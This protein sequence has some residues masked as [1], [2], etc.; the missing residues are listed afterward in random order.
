MSLPLLTQEADSHFVRLTY[1]NDYFTATD[2]YFTQGIRLEYGR[3]H[4][5]F[6]VAQEGYTPTSIRADQIL[7]GDRPYAGALFIG[8]GMADRAAGRGCNACDEAQY[9]WEIS[10]GVIGPA[11]LAA[12][13]Q[14]WIHRQTGNVE[15][16]G[17]KYQ[18]ENDLLLNAKLQLAQPL[19]TARH[20]S[21]RGVAATEV[22]TYRIHTEFSLPTEVGWLPTAA[23][24]GGTWLYFRP[25]FRLVGYDA[26]LQGGI[27]N[28]GR[29]PYTL[30]GSQL[31]R[32]VGTVTGGVHFGVAGI[33]VDFSHTYLSKEFQ[34][35]RSHAWGT[36]V[37]GYSW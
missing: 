4:R 30:V 9:S 26:T 8:Y 24:K 27:F 15:P 12:A 3:R 1:A 31:S 20:F 21:V 10:L 29:S 35:G 6:F 32:M 16:R 11:S 33:S 2:Y 34:S 19:V 5:R 28:G 14:K 23:R 22:G 17:W 37:L 18:I 36:V 25:A 13:E 7:V